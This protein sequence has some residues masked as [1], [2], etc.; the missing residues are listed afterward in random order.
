ME[1]DQKGLLQISD[2][3]VRDQHYRFTS[4]LILQMLLPAPVK[5]RKQELKR[6][7]RKVA[8]LMWAVLIIDEVF[9]TYV[10]SRRLLA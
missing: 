6:R 2:G 7:S 5:N 4:V 10:K 9:N 8:I 3:L 1:T